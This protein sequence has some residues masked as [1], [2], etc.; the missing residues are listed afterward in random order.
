MDDARFFNDEPFLDQEE[1]PDLL[2]HEQYGQHAV[3]LLQRVRAQTETG[4]LALIGP[5]G[6]KKSTVL[7]KVI[8][9]LRAQDISTDTSLVAELNPWPCVQA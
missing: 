5:W 9:Q 1:G 2:G 8:R 4:V 6:S 3:K 7:G